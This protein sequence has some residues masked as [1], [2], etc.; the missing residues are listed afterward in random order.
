MCA[1]PRVTGSRS[2]QPGRPVAVL[3]G[4]GVA[5]AGELDGLLLR[6]VHERGDVG[7][8]V[9]GLAVDVLRLR[10]ADPVRRGVEHR[11]AGWLL[12]RPGAGDA[13]DDAG[14]E[15]EQEHDPEDRHAAS[16][17]PVP[18]ARPR[19]RVAG[20]GGGHVEPRGDRERGPRRD[21]ARVDREVG[22]AG[23]LHLAP[24]RGDEADR[25]LHLGLGLH[26]Q[27]HGEV[28]L[29][30]AL[31]P[32]A[33]DQLP[34]E[35][36]GQVGDP[37]AALR[38]HPVDVVPDH[39]DV[40]AGVE[41]D[42]RGADLGDPEPAV[43]LVAQL[44]RLVLAVAGDRD[45]LRVAPRVRVVLVDAVPEPEDAVLAVD[46]HV[47]GDRLGD[48]EVAVLVDVEVR[49]VRRDRGVLVVGRRLAVPEEERRDRQQGGD[50]QHA[51]RVAHEPDHERDSSG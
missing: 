46:R 44:E 28:G 26:R 7:L 45:V 6:G 35:L 10:G 40:L 11:E 33:G 39:V 30:D 25:A 36:A 4:P 12:P 47:D 8:A 17:D 49:D 3:D 16:E 43:V 50:D 15:A 2:A 23:A 21:R 13:A 27:V 20:L 22:G 51:D 14:S 19:Q 31:L 42:V 32:A 34:V 41:R 5:V 48:L 29:V 24:R 9:D 18:A 37:V 38:D 1:L